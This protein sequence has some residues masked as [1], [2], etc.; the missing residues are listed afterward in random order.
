MTKDEALKLALDTL[1]KVRY[2]SDSPMK[3]LIE[4]A[5]DSITEVLEQSEPDLLVC[6]IPPRPLSYSLHSYHMA[7]SGG[8]LYYTWQDKP[9]R[10]LYDLIA[11]VRYYANPQSREWVDLTE[12]DLDEV[13]GSPM[14]LEHSGLTAFARSVEK[15]VKEK[16]NG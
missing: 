11:A 10:L 4:T 1:C 3:T 8:E 14:S 16:N 12:D 7:P 9:H 15:K 2:T 6:N 5:T 13:N